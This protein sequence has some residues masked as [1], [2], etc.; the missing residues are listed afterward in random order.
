[1]AQD[2][3]V[4][5]TA[6]VPESL[7]LRFKMFCVPRKVDMQDVLRVMVEKL[8]TEGQ[9]E[10]PSRFV[11]EVLQQV[12]PAADRESEPRKVLPMSRRPGGRSKK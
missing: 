10:Q 5:L 4:K 7:R 9:T 11:K 2:P 1:M 6:W 12:M 8:L 3:I